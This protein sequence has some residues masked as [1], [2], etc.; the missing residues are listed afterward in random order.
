MLATCVLVL[1]AIPEMIKM[2]VNDF[3]KI[4][5]DDLLNRF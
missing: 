4:F 2:N 3:R 5:H 1:I